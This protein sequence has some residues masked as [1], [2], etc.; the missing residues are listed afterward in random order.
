MQVLSHMKM[1][2]A[3]VLSIL[4]P[5]MLGLAAMPAHALRIPPGIQFNEAAETCV[6]NAFGAGDCVIPGIVQAFSL[7]LPAPLEAYMP[8][9]LS[10]TTDTPLVTVLNA[11]CGNQ[12]F[13]TQPGG[14]GVPTFYQANSAAC[15]IV[16]AIK[17]GA[18]L[19]GSLQG[20]LTYSYSWVSSFQQDPLGSGWA[21][22]APNFGPTVTID[23]PLN[24]YLTVTLGDP[25]S[26]GSDLLFG[27]NG[28]AV[29]NSSTADS[30]LRAPLGLS[31]TSGGGASVPAPG[32]AGLFGLALAGFS[33]GRRR[34]T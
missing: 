28:E 3:K 16:V 5:G 6:L 32:V 17:P 13:N 25:S 24:S 27:S 20:E 19:A 2:N 14:V 30:S 22:G 21:I 9:L 34:K 18:L 12:T 15:N 10:V 23:P 31:P 26:Q 11:V 29:G 4:L 7:G 1:L 33:F 8:H